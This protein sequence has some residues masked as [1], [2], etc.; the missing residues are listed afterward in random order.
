MDTPHRLAS[1]PGYEK[2]WFRIDMGHLMAHLNRGWARRNYARSLSDEEWERLRE[3][4]QDLR[5]IA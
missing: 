4:P 5:P 2:E 3:Y 1:E